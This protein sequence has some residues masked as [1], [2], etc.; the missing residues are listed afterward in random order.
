M[1]KAEVV[2][3]GVTAYEVGPEA[4]EWAVVTEI[5]SGRRNSTASMSLDQDD[6]Q[7]GGNLHQAT[8]RHGPDRGRE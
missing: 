2:E 5:A 4:T 7:S 6:P 3:Y 8:G 1:R